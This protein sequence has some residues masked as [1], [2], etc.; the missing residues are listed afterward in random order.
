MPWTAFARRKMHVR[1]LNRTVPTGGD[2]LR[3]DLRLRRGAPPDDARQ[4]LRR[5]ARA[6]GQR[7][8][9]AASAATSKSAGG[10]RARAV[11]QD[12]AEATCMRAAT[13]RTRRASRAPRAART[14]C[15][16]RT[17]FCCS[18]GHTIH[19][20]AR[21]AVAGLRAPES[22]R[23]RIKVRRPRGKRGQDRHHVAF[24]RARLMSGYQCESEQS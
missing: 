13:S 16:R 19:S 1:H 8:A 7:T 20:A 6:G 2:A 10:G 12:I 21:A 11:L 9:R 5:A 17:A 14:S 3:L 22:C 18:R 24:R 23:A 4:P 15:R